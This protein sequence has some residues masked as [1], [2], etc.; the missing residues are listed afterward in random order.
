MVLHTALCLLNF[1]QINFLFCK[2]IG[3]HLLDQSGL[4]P[5]R[6]PDKTVYAASKFVSDLELT[7]PCEN[8]MYVRLALTDL[9]AVLNTK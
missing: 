3:E 8:T 2:L 9:I 1:T 7:C 6:K 5:L 4:R